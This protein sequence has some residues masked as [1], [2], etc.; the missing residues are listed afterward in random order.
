MIACMS[1]GQ[2]FR[3]SAAVLPNALNGCDATCEYQGMRASCSARIEWARQHIFA[4][5]FRSCKAAHDLVLKQCATCTTCTLNISGCLTRFLP[6]EQ[7]ETTRVVP[8]KTTTVSRVALVTTIAAAATTEATTTKRPSTSSIAALVPRTTTSHKRTDSR[9]DVPDG[10]QVDCEATCTYKDELA[11]CRD[12]VLWEASREFNG[13]DDACELAHGLV[14]EQCPSC[15]L[16]LLRETGC[17]ASATPESTLPFECNL[18][19][20]DW[21]GSWPAAKQQWCCLHR[22]IGCASTTLGETHDC[23]GDEVDSW[24]RSKS[25]WCCEHKRVGCSPRGAYN[26]RTEAVEWQVWSEDHRTWCFEHSDFSTLH[27]CNPGQHDWKSSWSEGKMAWCCLYDTRWWSDKKEWCCQHQGVACDTVYHE[28]SAKF[29]VGHLRTHR[30]ICFPAI[31]MFAACLGCAGLLCLVAHRLFYCN[32]GG[33]AAGHDANREHHLA[34][35]ALSVSQALVA[36]TIP[37]RPSWPGEGQTQMGAAKRMVQLPLV[38]A[39][40]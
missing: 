9:V 36:E 26:C 37:G 39:Q 24:P 30:A 13:R 35:S 8:I 14:L 34:Y 21:E 11:T 10:N 22:G 6:A 15:A 17:S 3:N 28:I 18:G 19:L 33:L 5:D 23:S 38:M 2:D 40:P 25:I 7:I 32:D 27:T 29:N 16:C 12:R 31:V 4:N 20:V 1:A